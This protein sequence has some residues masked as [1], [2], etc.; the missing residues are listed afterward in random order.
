MLWMHFDPDNVPAEM[1]SGPMRLGRQYATD[2]MDIDT[3][4]EITRYTGKV[5]I[6][7]GD[8]D[9]LVDIAESQRAAKAYAAAGADVQFY[10]IPDGA[11]IFLNPKHIRMAA[12]LM[13]EFAARIHG[14]E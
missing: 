9:T 8:R 13:E 3:L 11:H 14:K 5:L 6:L 12:D 10:V 1:H 2:V 4:P 7:H